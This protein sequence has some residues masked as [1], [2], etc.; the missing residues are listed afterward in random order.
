M[1]SRKK[2]G[3]RYDVI[4]TEL[5]SIGLKQTGGFIREEFLRE[6][7]GPQGMKVYREMRDNPAPLGSALNAIEMLARQVC[8]EMEPP[9]EATDEEKKRTDRVQTSL[10][11]MDVP[12][13]EYIASFLSMLVFGFAPHEIVFKV[14]EGEKDDPKTSSRY[15][16]GM[17]AWAKLPLRPQETVYRWD[18]GPT[19]EVLGLF[20]RVP[21]DLQKGMRYIPAAK[22]LNFKAKAAGGN[23]EGRSVLR[24]AY[25]SWYFAKRI[26]ELE[27]IGI[28]RDLAGLPMFQ[29]PA[30]C[31]APNASADLAAVAEEAKNIVQSVRNDDEAGL[32]I[33]SQIV[34]GQ[35]LYKFS[36]L[37][38]GGTRA[39]DTNK[40]IE[41][42]ER[43]MTQV[44]LTDFI[45]LGHEGVGSYALS[46]DK[47]AL[48]ATA[49]GGWLD[50]IKDLIN[51]QAMPQLMRVNGWPADR[52]PK[53]KHGDIEKQD[54]ARW[55]DFVNKMVAANIITADD[56]LEGEARKIGEIAPRDP[57]SPKRQPPAAT[58]TKPA[59]GA[60]DEGKPSEEN[61][62][63]EAA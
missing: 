45:M 54:L 58:N 61:P 63:A 3:K 39:V 23:P 38:T 53:L 11:D 13:T 33:P 17:I 15:D 42:L 10:H 26:Q 20:Q 51:L 2:T 14:C 8:W 56:N 62:G 60:P 32:V 12:W 49:L 5:G 6:L 25:F 35:Q 36:L 43:R 29:I 18:L 30:E 59:G 52:A 27:G 50:I 34:D 55:G 16:D 19:G 48:F 44:L 57:S 40:I 22:F 47:T 9:F 46:S 7:Q 21:Y 41:R 1:A 24:S 37:S 4:G 31:L 28:E